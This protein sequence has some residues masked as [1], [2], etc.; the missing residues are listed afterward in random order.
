MLVWITGLSGSGKTTLCRAIQTVV[1][2]RMP[3]VIFLDGDEIR[4]IF[5]NTLGYAE[6]DRVFGVRRIQRMIRMFVEQG[7]PVVISVLYARSDLLAWNRE[8][9]SDYFEV[10]LNASIGTVQQRDSKGL[11][12]LAA[13]G[14]MPNVVGLD[15]PWH[16]PENPDLVFDQDAP[17]AP[18]EMAGTVIRSVPWLRPCL[19]G[20]PIDG[21]E[22]S[23]VRS[24]NS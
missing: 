9:F 10:Y 11:Y 24:A 6:E 7:H 12:N 15:I 5:G 13:Q 14:E 20:D 18:D 16:E 19:D 21:D 2:P 3:E 1:K 4:G 17:P 8:T 22:D 23:L